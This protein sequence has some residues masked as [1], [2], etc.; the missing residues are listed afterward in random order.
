MRRLR[1][2]EIPMRMAAARAA[3]DMRLL[4]V[5]MTPES[6]RGTWKAYGVWFRRFWQARRATA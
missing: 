3:L 5:D 1:H 4:G 6:V 2:E